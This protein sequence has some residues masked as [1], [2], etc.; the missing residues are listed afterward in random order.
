MY[1]CEYNIYIYIETILHLPIT[2]SIKCT[3]Y[4][5]SYKFE[6]IHYTSYLIK[7]I[8]LDIARYMY[9]FVMY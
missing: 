7:H 9:I 1:M 5:I 4:I 6:L 2:Y 8:I 3:S